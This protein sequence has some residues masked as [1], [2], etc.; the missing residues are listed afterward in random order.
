MYEAVLDCLTA[1]ARL[2]G[3]KKGSKA[4][5]EGTE[6]NCLLSSI[7]SPQFLPAVQINLS[8]LSYAKGLSELLQGSFQYVIQAYNEF[9]T[10]KDDGLAGFWSNAEKEYKAIFENTEEMAATA[11]T[12]MQIPRWCGRQTERITL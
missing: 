7:T 2:S 3:A 10:V 4:I 12:E 1:I 11:G 8:V 5:T 9:K 6:G